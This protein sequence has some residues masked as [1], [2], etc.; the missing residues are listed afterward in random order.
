MKKWGSLPQIGSFEIRIG[1][2]VFAL[3][4]LQLEAPIW[5]LGAAIPSCNGKYKGGLTPS[6]EELTD[7]L[8]KN[9]EELRIQWQALGVKITDRKQLARI[10]AYFGRPNLCEAN[11]RGVNLRGAD[12]PGADLT[13][14][15]L[16]GA[17]L[18]NANLRGANFEGASLRDAH[19]ANAK[20][21]GANLGGGI[22]GGL[23]GATHEG[24]PCGAMFWNADLENAS[25][26]GANLR[27]TNFT[28]NLTNAR[29]NTANLEGATFI[30]ANLTNAD[31]T[32]ANLESAILDGANLKGANLLRAKLRGAS[33]D[34]ANVEN[35]EFDLLPG[36]LPDPVFLSAAEGLQ[37]VKFSTESAGL[38]KLRSEF[39][40]LRLRD[41]ENQLTYAIMRSELRRTNLKG[42]PLHG[43][44]ERWANYL[45][46]DLTCQY[47]MSSKR[48][49]F[50]VAIFSILFGAIY[51]FAQIFPEE[52]SGIWAVWDEHR[53]DKTEGADA[54][55]RLNAGFPPARAKGR[56]RRFISISAL[57]AYFSLLSALRIGWSGLTFGTWISRMQRRE[58]SLHATGW[59]R[60]VSGVQSLISVY[61]VALTILTNFGTPFE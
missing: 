21:D 50:I 57:A 15:N 2:I 4:I 5:A 23:G 44:V 39:K 37:F 43:W 58:Y 32:Q 26:M 55:Q 22:C 51:V 49:L 42:V 36:S 10:I 9:E 45:F 34:G 52:H 14:A 59:V 30:S 16:E 61:L 53:I 19:L 1:F 29:L 17:H 41:P 28:G 48:P 46:F 31:F 11:L 40:D 6:P 56:V 33:F 18:E 8:K 60:V 24:P 3:L 7:I 38:V 35:A 12:L 47:G 25:L 27:G 20:L 54:P 13:G